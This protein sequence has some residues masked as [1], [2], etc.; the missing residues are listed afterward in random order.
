MSTN[1]ADQ[2][3]KQ[4][5][6]MIVMIRVIIIVA[7]NER[8]ESCCM[9]PEFEAQAQRMFFDVVMKVLI[10]HFIGDQG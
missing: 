7:S 1:V 8:R 2:G 3:L 4:T 10:F 5:P 6:R 9:K